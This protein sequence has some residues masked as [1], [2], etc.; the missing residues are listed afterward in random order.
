MGT[1]GHRAFCCLDA[2]NHKTGI[3]DQSA[4]DQGEGYHF[5][6][7]FHPQSVSSPF[8]LASSAARFLAR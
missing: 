3:L 6:L 4:P 5:V 8:F 1:D 2:C 7:F